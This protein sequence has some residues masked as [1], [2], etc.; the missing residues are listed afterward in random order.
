MDYCLESHLDSLMFSLSR[1]AYLSKGLY[2]LI[3]PERV[4]VNFYSTVPDDILSTIALLPRRRYY[5]KLVRSEGLLSIVTVLIF[6]VYC[7][8]VY[9][10]TLKESLPMKTSIK[11]VVQEY[12]NSHAPQFKLKTLPVVFDL[13]DENY[14]A[15]LLFLVYQLSHPSTSTDILMLLFQ[16]RDFDFEEWTVDLYDLISQPPAWFFSTITKWGRFV[17]TPRDLVSFG[18][19]NRLLSSVCREHLAKDQPFLARC[20]MTGDSWSVQH[21]NVFEDQGKYR[22]NWDYATSTH[23]SILYIRENIKEYR[24]FLQ[25]FDHRTISNWNAWY[26]ASRVLA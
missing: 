16:I 20:I 3:Y 7:R 15:R 13:E 26:S 14:L 5:F 6:D 12:L 23:P 18:C 22:K 4:A 19:V 1:G 2:L 8:L 10:M 9:W 25:V 17:L 11:R 21:Q 24:I